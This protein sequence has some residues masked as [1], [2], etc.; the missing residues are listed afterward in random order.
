MPHTRVT[1]LDSNLFCLFLLAAARAADKLL[2]SLPGRLDWSQF[3]GLPVLATCRWGCM[4]ATMAGWHRLC[5]FFGAA[6]GH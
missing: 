3:V 2:Q 5:N 4:S 1:R 6:M